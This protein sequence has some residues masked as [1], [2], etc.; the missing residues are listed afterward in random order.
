MMQLSGCL[1]GTEQSVAWVLNKLL[2]V[3]GLL[4]S[5]VASS[6]VFGCFFFNFPKLSAKIVTEIEPKCIAHD[7]KFSALH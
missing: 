2:E 7:V 5:P 3:E 1:N 6:L 4:Q